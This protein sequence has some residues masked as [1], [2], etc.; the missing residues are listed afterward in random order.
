MPE[1]MEPKIDQTGA[2]YRPPK[3]LFDSACSGRENSAISSLEV[4][5][6]LQRFG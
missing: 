1:I 4:A 6:H 2:L 3:T 5:Q